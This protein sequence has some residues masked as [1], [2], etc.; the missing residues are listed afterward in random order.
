MKKIVL[1]VI[2]FGL[3]SAAPALAAIYPFGGLIMKMLPPFPGGPC[4]NGPSIVVGAPVGGV[5][6]IPPI[7]LFPF[8]KIK[9][10]SWVLGIAASPL[11]GVI[12]VVG[13]SL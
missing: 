9:P 10:G 4:I 3:F 7:T 6:V 11:C 8:Y 12:P 13:T 1:F 5:F 2:M